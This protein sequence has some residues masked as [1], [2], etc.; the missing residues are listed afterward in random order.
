MSFNLRPWNGWVA[1]HCPYAILYHLYITIPSS[2]SRFHVNSLPTLDITVFFDL[3]KALGLIFVQNLSTIQ[4]PLF[5][6]G[7]VMWVLIRRPHLI[8]EHTWHYVVLVLCWS[9]PENVQG[10][11][12]PLY[13]GGMV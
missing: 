13:G 2:Q 4:L 9:F 3:F 12:M 1:K 6:H 10:Y 7:L 11:L 5:L 8:R